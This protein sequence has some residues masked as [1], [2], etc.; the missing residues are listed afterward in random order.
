MDGRTDG[1]ALACVLY[2][3]LAGVPPFRR[4]TAAETMWAHL[5]EEPPRLESHPALDPV[6]QRGMAQDRDE[7]YPTCAALIDAAREVLAPRASRV[8]MLV[9][10]GLAL[11]AVAFVGAVLASSS[12]QPGAAAQAP[13]GNG[14]AVIEPSSERIGAYVES[15]GAPSNIAVGAGGIWF[16][17]A[18]DRT[19]T[20]IDPESKAVTRRFE[21]PGV[22]APTD[23]AAGGGAVWVG[24]G[25]GNGGNWTDTVYRI[26][27]KT[28]WIT[29]T[30]ELPGPTGPP[31][32][33]NGGFT[34]MAVGAGAVWATGGGAVARIDP[35]TGTT[36]TTVDA[37]ASR[38]AA[39][40]EGVWFIS[41]L[42]LGVVTPIDPE[43]NA[44]GKPIRIGEVRLTGIAVGGGSIWVTAEQEGIV[45]RITPGK[46]PVTLPIDAGPGVNYIAYGAGAVWVANSLKGTL[47]RIDPATNTVVAET[48]IGAVQSLAAGA[49]SAW[50]STAG[51]TR[52]GTLPA[53]TCKDESG[54][55]RPDVLIASDL[56]LHGLGAAVA[57][58]RAM[59]D[60][61]RAVLSQHGYRAG[62]YTVGYRSCDDSTQQAGTSEPRRCA[63]NANAYA[64]V[65]RLVAVIGPLHS[66]CASIEVPILNRAPGGPL[67]MISPTNSDV[68]LTRTGVPPPFSYRGTPDVYYP[69]GTRHYVRLTSP[70]RSRA[71]RMPC[72]PSG[73]G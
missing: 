64:T 68:G 48:P 25:S 67:A 63:A 22:W 37:D 50:V 30:A 49:G 70:N 28:A 72:S 13:E 12:D 27:P 71:R 61:I 5:R 69:I 14:V 54:G 6:L 55:G 24:T 60:T 26:D 47:S 31:A 1:Y 58:P 52:A 53:S 56:P 21:A 39:G 38:I 17:H 32:D 19:V 15:A 45:W 20:R 65:D 46:S 7:R 34:Q 73:S 2:E 23:V 44:T 62:R 57:V 8:R 40:R 4:A 43:T 42:S 29:Q 33:R 35:R 36:V 41:S 3:C 11:I 9:A 66:S 10:G 18:E 59:V 51:A 16:L